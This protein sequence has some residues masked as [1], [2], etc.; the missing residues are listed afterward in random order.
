[1]VNTLEMAPTQSRR[2]YTAGFK[3]EVIAFAEQNGGN[4]AAERKFGVTEKVIRGWRKQKDALQRTKK[5][6][7][8]FRGRAAKKTLIPEGNLEKFV[9]VKRKAARRG[10]D[11][12]YVNPLRLQKRRLSGMF[13]QKY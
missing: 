11:I 12:V 7:K 13:N 10:V 9:V 1:M 3:L 5:S 6:R 4:M 8:S 2:S